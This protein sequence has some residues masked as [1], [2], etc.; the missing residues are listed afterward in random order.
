MRKGTSERK[1]R[2]DI[3]GVFRSVTGSTEIWKTLLR[4]R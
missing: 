4:E 1:I 2:E 3:Q